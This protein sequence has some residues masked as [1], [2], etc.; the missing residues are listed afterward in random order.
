MEDYF[1]LTQHCIE[2][3]G[4]RLGLTEKQAERKINLAMKYGKSSENYTTSWERKYLKSQSYDGVALAYDSYC[5]IITES[6]IC[7]TVYPL[8]SWW[9]KKKNYNGKERIRNPKKYYKKYYQSE[10]I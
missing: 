5:Y 10:R 4:Q 3:A 9:E 1:I 7:I 8:P 2:R 6:G